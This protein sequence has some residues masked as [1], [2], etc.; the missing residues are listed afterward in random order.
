MT[1]QEALQSAFKEVSEAVVAVVHLFNVCSLARSNPDG[2]VEKDNID[3][4]PQPH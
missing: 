4:P 3:E 1:V 2:E